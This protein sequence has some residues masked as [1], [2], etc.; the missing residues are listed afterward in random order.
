MVLKE[1]NIMVLKGFSLRINAIVLKEANVMV[2]KGL[3]LTPFQTIDWLLNDMVLKGVNDSFQDK[4]SD[5][6]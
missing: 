6:V 4:T 2:L 5:W 3:P 1:A